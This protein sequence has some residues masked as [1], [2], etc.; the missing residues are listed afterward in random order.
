MKELLLR[1]NRLTGITFYLCGVHTNKM[2]TVHEG[3]VFD[4]DTPEWLQKFISGG[5]RLLVFEQNSQRKQY[6]MWQ[7]DDSNVVVIL[8][9]AHFTSLTQILNKMLLSLPYSL[10]ETGEASAGDLKTANNMLADLQ[11]RLDKALNEKAAALDSLDKL[12]KENT[13]L[14]YMNKDQSIRLKDA[15]AKNLELN[16]TLKEYKTTSAVPTATDS[17]IIQL[18]EEN[19]R[20]AGEIQQMQERYQKLSDKL[21]AIRQNTSTEYT[22]DNDTSKGLFKLINALNIVIET[23]DASMLDLKKLAMFV[24]VPV[25]AELERNPAA[26]KA[27]ISKL[28]GMERSG[29][30]TA[31]QTKKL[32]E[33]VL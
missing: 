11:Q 19:A 3:V 13:S 26:V 25:Q 14:A 12:T 32:N 22:D 21:N 4:S 23:G 8:D 18:R 6:Y 28:L 20:F 33:V 1:L 30:L 27:I 16:H 29:Q 2:Q 15:L 31:F 7:L 9:D 17:S 24:H 5:N 10:S